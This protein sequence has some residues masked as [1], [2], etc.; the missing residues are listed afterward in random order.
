M[1]VNYHRENHIGFIEI[2]RPEKL[3]ALSHELLLNLK[4]GLSEMIEDPK[5]QVIVFT[6]AGDRGFC[7]GGDVVEVYKVGEERGSFPRDFFHLEFEVDK[8]V[9]HTDKIV[10]SYLDGIA[11]GGGVGL[12]I[13]GDYSIVNERTKWALPEA[14][15]GMTP[16]VGLGTYISKL[17]QAYGLY[18]T[19]LG[20]TLPGNGLISLGLATHLISS[21]DWEDIV[22]EL[23]EAKIYIGNRDKNKETIDGILEKYKAP[24][25]PS[26]LSEIHEELMTHFNFETLEEII[27][28]LESSDTEFAKTTA[29]GLRA[30]DPVALQ[31]IFY[32]YFEGKK[33]SR[34]LCFDMDEIILDYLYYKGNMREGIRAQMVDKDGKPKFIPATIEEVDVAEIKNILK[35]PDSF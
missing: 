24:L 20:P 23:K 1:S 25:E 17:S 29:E 21:K 10:L 16:D 12:S 7:A 11:M 26:Y 19:L 30:R 9:E 13:G 4:V 15:L 32:K 5:I 31:V 33:W 22:R 8:L 35:V 28:S 18:L 14:I 2:N 34:D 3:N 6:G 27:K